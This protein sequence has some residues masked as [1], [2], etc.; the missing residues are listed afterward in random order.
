M[1]SL[2]RPPAS[3]DARAKEPFA[4][5]IEVPRTS[6]AGRNAAA[7]QS[8][9]LVRAHLQG[10]EAQRTEIWEPTSD[11]GYERRYRRP[12]PGT[13]EL[14]RGGIGRVL[15]VFDRSIGRHVAMKEL[16]PELEEATNPDASS[17]LPLTSRFLR[18]ARITG[19]LEHP[20]IV[21]VYEL[22]QNPEGRFYYT[23]RVVRG[24]TLSAAISQAKDLGQRLALINHFSG[25]C[26]AIAYAHSQGVVHRDIKPDN[27]MI[28]EFGETFVLD[29][30]LVKVAEQHAPVELRAALCASLPPR[31]ALDGTARINE[32]LSLED[33]RQ[34]FLVGTPPYMSPEQILGKV[35]SGDPR[36][37][38]WS[39]G[40]VLHL[41][42]T[43]RRPFNGS[44]LVELTNAILGARL[45]PLNEA[46]PGIPRD[47]A[48]I[49]AR[50]LA[51]NPRDRYPSARELARDI[52]AYQAGEKVLAHEYGSLEL[53][54]RFV[55][56]QRAAVTV[57]ML[58]LTTVTMLGMAAVGRISQARDRAVAAEERARQGEHQAHL[59]LADVLM[60][61][62][63]SEQAEGNV[64]AA[65]LLAAGALELL[66]RPDARGTLVA[67]SNTDRPEVEVLPN[68][69]AGARAV[70][71]DTDRSEIAWLDGNT[72]R[73]LGAEH[74]VLSVPWTLPASTAVLS[75]HQHGWL[76]VAPQGATFLLGPTGSLVEL[77]W[78]HHKGLG[79]AVS[80][81]G[82]RVAYASSVGV[83][84][85]NG[86]G[87]ILDR[88][89][90]PQPVTALVFDST[91]SKLAYGTQRGE[92]GL[93]EVAAGH[94]PMALGRTH[95]TTRA[96]A[97]SPKGESLAVGGG[98]GSLSIWDVK[99]RQ[100]R[101]APRRTH[102]PIEK[103]SW[104]G[105]GR[106]IAMV[107]DSMG[108]E[109]LEVASAERWLRLPQ[110][111][112]INSLEFDAF[113]DLWVLPE[114]RAP[115]RL[116]VVQQVPRTELVTSGNVLALTWDSGNTRLLAGGLGDQGVCYLDQ[117]LG[118][119]TDRLPV[120][121]PLVRK[122]V[123][124]PYDAS[125]AVG[126][127]SRILEVW[128]GATKLPSR[129]V[130]V[131]MDEVRALVFDSGQRRL[132]VGGTGPFV[133]GIDPT[134]GVVESRIAVVA[135][136]QSMALLARA[137][138]LMVGLRDGRI[139]LF[140]L[141][142]HGLLAERAT[143]GD[144]TMD[145]VADEPL[146]W[147]A[148]AGADGRV[149][150]F[151]LPHLTPMES[152]LVHRGRATALAYSP[153]QQLLASAGEDGKVV[154]YS[155]GVDRNP[156][157]ILSDHQGTVRTLTFDPTERWLL[158]GGDD[159]RVRRW[160]LHT[161]WSDPQKTRRQLEE[162]LG[163]RLQAGQVV[164][165]G[166]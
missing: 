59:R 136:V 102:G 12:A 96:L 26:Q 129:F 48:A 79:L 105:D 24:R 39:L 119:C 154:L 166:G 21:P 86:S 122:M 111:G 101:D 31:R 153:G 49:V 77:P 18:E 159:T 3:T 134:T 92:L 89:V 67:L 81:S 118:G 15:L 115:Y 83:D 155:V 8:T 85:V 95:S 50:A 97:F 127:T 141:E 147:V 51:L 29:W 78:R 56:R 108:L 103:L 19:Q 61:R 68:P 145:L 33:T 100:L 88:F 91:G 27:V 164:A 165:Q 57:A 156:I 143:G 138:Q 99:A 107:S 17:A 157:A 47:L 140:D 109:L 133:L 144:W 20:N 23:M 151:A 64:L 121:I 106:W 52:T 2:S 137:R 162:R 124:S 1:A 94:A 37:D 80:P 149:R 69:A 148:S 146:G 98:D 13:G 117:A 73:V 142:G 112:G 63:Q 72:L 11:T 42:L 125:L 35:P 40:V 4:T 54:V 6:D 116:H 131:E 14:G 28:G 110:S 46:E 60:E 135:A 9:D 126:G 120:R 7:S 82:D 114:A 130:D 70:A 152:F 113:G 90:H 41:L 34:G 58:A 16:L 22:G 30:G 87:E 36:C 75:L 71:I 45:R 65:E 104:S 62:A 93:W 32:P 139:Q 76:C 5:L 158:S 132:W 123:S 10:I 160:S 84:L 25:L 163:L 38:V 53:L 43:G 55:Q 128:D 66:E 150:L 74:P 161:L 44:T